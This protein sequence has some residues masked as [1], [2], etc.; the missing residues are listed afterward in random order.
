[1]FIYS[2]LDTQSYNKREGLVPD[3]L[4]LKKKNNFIHVQTPN[5]PSHMIIHSF[6]L[7]RG[8]GAVI[9]FWLST[10]VRY[11]TF[12]SRH[13]ALLVPYAQMK[14]CHGSL[15]VTEWQNSGI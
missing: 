13:D 1:M 12:L 15:M 8:K 4:N 2:I 9:I 5:L 10:I 6:I 7:K 11:D 14:L 3:I